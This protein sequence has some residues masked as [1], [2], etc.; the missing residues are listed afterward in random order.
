M[1]RRARDSLFL[2]TVLA[3]PTPAAPA[4]PDPASPA[5]PAAPAPAAPDPAAPAPAAPDPAAAKAP[6]RALAA[7]PDRSL[8]VGVAG[9]APFV[10]R[11][12][13]TLDGL[14]IGAWRAV[15]ARLNLD[16]EFAEQPSVRRGLE[17]VAAGELD[18]MVGP[19]SITAERAQVV[20]FTQPYFQSSLAIATR[21]EG[22]SLLSRVGPFLSRAFAVGLVTLL[23]V[24]GVVGALLWL[25][26]R[27]KNA[28]MFP[29]DPLRGIGNGVWMAL[30]TMTTVGYGDRVPLTVGGRVITGIWMVVA[31]LSVS[32]LTAGIASALTLSQL[33]RGLIERARDLEGRRVAVV[34]ETVGA[35]FARDHDARLAVTT[36]VG[37]ALDLLGR[38]KVE[39]VVHDRPILLYEMNRFDDDHDLLIAEHVYEPQ[40][41]GF[42]AH[43][44]PAVDLAPALSVGLLEVI[45]AGEM[46]ALSA[47]WLGE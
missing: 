12:G 32:S 19:I 2:S 4:A 28:T 37:A 30:V 21:A 13:N 24:L 31:M 47:K 38:G 1:V 42:A 33:E 11:D 10:V 15:A 18:V 7:L 46:R 17:R 8:R 25:T 27:R 26:E 45:E 5:A 35:R 16:F 22:P 40:G 36:S 29:R 3:A 44:D 34:G 20:R 6:A 9:S 14:S 23:V 41:Y 39:A 43:P